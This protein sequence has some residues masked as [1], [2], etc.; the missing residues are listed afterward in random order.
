MR[1]M[2]LGLVL[3]VAVC[4]APAVAGESTGGPRVELRGGV[5]WSHGHTDPVIGAATG[6]DFDLGKGSFA[7]AEVS[8]EKMLADDT[9]WEWALTGRLGTP[10][11]KRGKVFANAG[12]TFTHYE[13]APHLGGGYEHHIG[14]GKAYV[15][16]EYRHVFGDYHEV[17]AITLGIGTFF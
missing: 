6:Y 10:V 5:A 14:T 2:K 4:A 17:D 8:V 11:S 12:Y 7:G 1:F 13:E 15:A 3:A 9:H 16:L